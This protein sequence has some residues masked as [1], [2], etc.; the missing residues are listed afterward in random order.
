MKTGWLLYEESDLAQ[1]REFAE[2]IEREGKQRALDIQTVRVSE[3]ALGVR[4]GGELSLRRSGRE[5]LPD[6]VISR[7]RDELTSAQFEAMGVPVFN[8]ARVCGICN[9]K[10]RTQQFLA[11]IPMLETRFISHRYA[12]APDEGDFPLVVKPA[13][14]H[15][16]ENV[17]QVNNE[18]EWRE[19]VDQILPGDI[20]QQKIAGDAGKDLRVYVLF[21]E[22]AAGVLRT[23]R[24]GIISNFK[25]GGDVELHTL[26]PQ[27]QTLAQSVINRFAQAGAPLCLAGV[28]MLYD[29]GEPVL[30]EVEDVVGSRMLYQ[31][32][33]LDI[34]GLYLDAIRSRV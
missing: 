6:F 24:Q 20:V 14:G 30:S 27:E 8:G 28:D 12:V 1:N 4:A 15:G 21:G 32:S 10:R 5:I 29:Q 11:G 3:L 25:R 17:R 9:D 31:V 16:G 18:Y 19:A 22:I 13:R 33:K 34:A 23:A 7:Q 26:T 2:Y